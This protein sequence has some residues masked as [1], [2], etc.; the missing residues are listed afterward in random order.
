MDRGK[1]KSRSAYGVH[2]HTRSPVQTCL[3]SDQVLKGQKL[4]AWVPMGKGECPCK[5]E[6]YASISQNSIGKPRM[7]VPKLSTIAENNSGLVAQKRLWEH[8]QA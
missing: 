5:S 2:A 6:P 3:K 7:G 4:Y 1:V 8:A